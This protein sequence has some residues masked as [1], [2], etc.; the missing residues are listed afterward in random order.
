[1]LLLMG[2]HWK[3]IEIEK[4]GLRQLLVW[5][6]TRPSY[7]DPDFGGSRMLGTCHHEG[8]TVGSD[9]VSGNTKAPV[10]FAVKQFDWLSGLEGRPDLNRN[11]HHFGSISVGDFPAIPH[12]SWLFPA[13][14]GDLP[15]PTGPWYRLNIDFRT[16]GFVRNVRHPMAIGR[17]R[18]LPFRRRRVLKGTHVLGIPQAEKP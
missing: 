11:A 14:T 16:P 10:K 6:Q 1:M 9:V 2:E 3:G 12:P 8:L 7:D 18:T 13:V 5:Q 17:Q 15:T 4:L